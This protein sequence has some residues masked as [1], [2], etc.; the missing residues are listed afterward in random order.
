MRTSFH[1]QQMMRHCALLYELKK[2]RDLGSVEEYV[3]ED[4]EAN[5]DLGYGRSIGVGFQELLRTRDLDAAIFKAACSYSFW[6]S[7]K[8]CFEG[9]VAALQMLKQEFPLQL[10][11]LVLEEAAVKIRLSE[12]DWWCGFIDGVLFREDTGQYVIG[13]VKSCGQN[14]DNLAP[15]YQNSGQALGYSV[16][17]PTLLGEDKRALAGFEVLYLIAHIP[18]Q[19][20]LPKIKSYLFQ[21]TALDRKRWLLALYL[22]YEQYCRYKELGFWPPRGDSCMIYS[23][24]CELFGI[25]GNIN[26]VDYPPKPK[27]KIDLITEWDVDIDIQTLIENERQYND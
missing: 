17:L 21:K 27:D 13:E 23:R 25:C 20:W 19:Q 18:G 5:V 8:K 22:D 12:E 26:P 4:K 14:G 24:P 16:V 6:E 11:Q 3:E 10:Y 7:D 1:S 15:L 9:I 2:N